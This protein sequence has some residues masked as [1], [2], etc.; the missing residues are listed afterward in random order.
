[1]TKTQRSQLA[2]PLKRSDYGALVVLV[3]ERLN[4]RFAVLYDIDDNEYKKIFTNQKV[5]TDLHLKKK[6]IIR[7]KGD[8]QAA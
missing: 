8:L 6:L 7:I 4:N 1:M 5:T 3:C 2:K